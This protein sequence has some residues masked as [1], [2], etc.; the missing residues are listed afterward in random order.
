MIL[1]DGDDC[2]CVRND[3]INEENTDMDDDVDDNGEGYDN[4]DGDDDVVGVD[5]VDDVVVEHDDN[6]DD[7]HASRL[8]G[9]TLAP[10]NGC[11]IMLPCPGP[12]HLPHHLG[13]H[14][15]LQHHY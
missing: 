9:R 10:T 2:G 11:S 14:C 7:G 12:A 8:L 3:K 13:D 6:D 5:V 15:H 1:I 4:D